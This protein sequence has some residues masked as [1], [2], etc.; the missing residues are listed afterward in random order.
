VHDF[1]EVYG[2]RAQYRARSPE[3][4]VGFELLVTRR[5]AELLLLG[6][7]PL[8]AKAFVVRQRDREAEVER[9]PGPAAQ[10]APINV[11]RDLH[12]VTL[13]GADPNAI[14]REGCPYTSRLI[15]IG[16]GPHSDAPP[17]PT[18]G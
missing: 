16:A 2:L 1:P 11:L 17:G 18:E 13:R 6:I 12:A 5:E 14:A 4:E 8:G 10:F 15:A 3:V 7:G 9:F